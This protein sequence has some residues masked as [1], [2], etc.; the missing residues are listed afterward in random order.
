[1]SSQL[2]EILVTNAGGTVGNCRGPAVDRSGISGAAW[3]VGMGSMKA[4]KIFLFA[5]CFTGHRHVRV[6]VQASSDALPAI[7]FMKSE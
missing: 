2:S 7:Y 3:D 1:M 4:A 6:D 5:R